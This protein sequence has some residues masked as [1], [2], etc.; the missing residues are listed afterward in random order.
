MKTMGNIWGFISRHKYLIVLLAFLVFVGFVDENSLFYRWKLTRQEK[1][2]QS[3]ID[4]YKKEYK[5]S[6][7][8]LQELA[9]DSVE[10]ERIARENYL[11]KKENEDIFVFEY[12][13]AE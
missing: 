10:I 6:T 1:I 3:E 7:A 5:E 9:A 13:S 12:E 4:K 8:K 11:M 2:L